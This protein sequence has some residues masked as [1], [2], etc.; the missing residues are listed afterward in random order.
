MYAIRSYYVTIDDTEGKTAAPALKV[1]SADCATTRTT[2]Q[3]KNLTT[4]AKNAP[5][6]ISHIKDIV[7]GTYTI[8]FYVKV[9]SYNFV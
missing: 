7:A 8:S 2:G 1:V 5:T 6:N 9:T 4:G 3:T